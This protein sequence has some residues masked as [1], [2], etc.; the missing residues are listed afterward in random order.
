MKYT[1]L[2]STLAYQHISTLIFLFAFVACN[3]KLP[4]PVVPFEKTYG[5]SSNDYATAA[6]LV[7]NHIHIVGTSNNDLYWLKID[8][9]GSKI[10]E[11]RYGGSGQEEGYNLLQTADGNFVLLGITN[12][13][14]GSYD[15]FLVKINTVGDTLWQ[16]TYDNA[17]G[18]DQAKGIVETANGE[19]LILGTLYNG[20]NAYFHLMHLNA[21]GNKISQRSY[22]SL[23]EDTGV[24]IIAT[25]DGNYMLFGNRKNGDD[26]FYAMKINPQ[27]DSLWAATYG[28][29]DYEQAWSI[30]EMADNGFL[31]CGHSASAD[32]LHHFYAVKINSTGAVIWEKHFGGTAHDGCEAGMEMSNGEILLVGQTD[33]Y[34]SSR[35][36]LM[37]KTDA[38]GNELEQT[39]FGGDLSDKGNA[40][41]ESATAYYLIGQ[42]ASFSAGG[43]LDVYVVKRGK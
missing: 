21:D 26:D 15:I 34:G 9:D 22:S 35:G 25:S 12:S 11:K 20:S 23:H 6:I 32:P 30:D 17:N 3:D 10:S 19:L 28:G 41:V 42:S 27:G 13:F 1:F 33:S 37:V 31:L 14:G 5:G 40:L 43:D 38:N 16:K 36:M 18:F 24:Q 8:E 4:A 29:A 39:S 7:D 2:I